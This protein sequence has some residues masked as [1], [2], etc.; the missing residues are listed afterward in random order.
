MK[1]LLKYMSFHGRANRQRYWLTALSL[2]GLIFVSAMVAVM[3]TAVP[4][5]AVVII[6]VWVALFVAVFANAARRLHDRNKSAWW[7]LLFYV[8]PT[9][10]GMPAELADGTSEG[11][12]GLAALLALVGLPF[13]IW[14]L[15]EM[16]FLGGTLGPNRFGDDP[17][18]RAPL[19]PAVAQ[20][21]V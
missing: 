6:P 18:G 10:L 11:F 19:A 16:G 3:P 7:L 17:L 8:V 20:E 5:L 15:V 14:G 21:A 2:V 1:G 12:Q 4:L 9:I 13:S